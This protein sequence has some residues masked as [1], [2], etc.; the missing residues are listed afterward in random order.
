MKC[1]WAQLLFL[2]ILKNS[3]QLG[4]NDQHEYRKI[5]RLTKRRGK[6]GNLTP[7]PY[8]R[9]GY[10][11]QSE[12]AGVGRP[13]A[14]T[15]GG[16]Q[17]RVVQHALARSFKVWSGVYTPRGAAPAVSAGDKGSFGRA[18][19]ARP[20]NVAPSCRSCASL[21]S[22]VKVSIDTTLERGATFYGARFE[23]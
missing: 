14:R 7:L 19:R 16:F 18:P 9:A 6:I 10:D 21:S 2:K 13:G 20:G 15:G 23:F 17:N 8:G 11:F 4:S 3:V 5:A 1:T 22:Y 12:H